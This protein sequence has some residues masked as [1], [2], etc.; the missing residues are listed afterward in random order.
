MLAPRLEVRGASKT[1]GSTRVL[2]SVDLVIEPGEIHALIG[3]NG[4][5]KSTLVKILTGYHVPDPGMTLTLDGR[6]LG[7]PVQ[8][9]LVQARGVSVVHQDLGLL[10]HLTVSEN[11]GVGGYR[12]SRVLRRISW[13]R[14]DA[15]AQVVLTRLGVPVSPRELVGGLPAMRRAEVAIARA[16]RDHEPGT[17]LIILDEATRALPREELSRFHTLL[18]RVVAEGTS[19]LIVSHNLEEV[20]TLSD[21]VTILRDGRSV[22]SGLVTLDITEQDMAR[23]MLGK[24]VDSLAHR[25]AVVEPAPLAAITGLTWESASDVSLTVGAGE[26]VGLTGLPGSGFE[27][28]PSILSGGRSAF[29]GTLTLGKDSLDLRRASVADAMKAGVALVPER[30]ILEGLATEMSIRDNVA[31][32]S[33]S[34]RGSAFF[35]GRGWQ[36]EVAADAIDQLGIMTRSVSTLVKELSGGNQQKV[37][38]AKWLSVSPRLFLLHEPTQAVDVG[39]RRDLL[40]AVHDIAAQGVGVLLCSSEPSDLVEACDRILVFRAGEPLLELRTTNPDDVLEAVY[41][42]PIAVPEGDR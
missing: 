17:G 21:R 33:V 34:R 4:S 25:D 31:L 9:E 18:K 29:A 22:G 8:W 40:Q 35:V 10:D 27:A 15:I 16:L 24:S 13:K 30:R 3:Q 1:F 28:I 37:L 36:N 5:G 23:L 42:G 2:D 41:A 12:H 39:A 20:Q 26:V 6:P 14:Q 38:F 19:V 7:L 11:I 32:P